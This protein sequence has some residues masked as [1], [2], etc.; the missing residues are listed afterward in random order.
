MSH[1]TTQAKRTSVRAISATVAALLLFCAINCWLTWLQPHIGNDSELPEHGWSYWS[2]KAIRNTDPK[3]VNVVVLG[4]SL[5]SAAITECDATLKKQQLDLCFY[6]GAS[7]LDEQMRSQFHQS[8]QTLNLAAPGQIPSDAYL[9]MKAALAN[10]ITPGVVIYGVA[11]RDFIDHTLEDPCD[12]E[13]FHYFY[14]TMDMT[15]C[16]GELLKNPLRKLDST[17]RQTVYLYSRAIPC[18]MTANTIG[19]GTLR[20]LLNICFGGSQDIMERPVKADIL[21]QFRPFDLEPGRIVATPL[22]GRGPFL[23]NIQ[24]YKDRYKQPS[25]DAYSTQ[26]RFLERLV[27]LCQNHDIEII[28]VNMPITRQ[29]LELLDNTWQRRYVDDLSRIASTHRID[30]LDQCEFDRYFHE[31]F[32]DSV[33]LNGVGGKKFI[34]R[35]VQCMANKSGAARAMLA[36]GCRK[37]RSMATSR[38]TDFAAGIQ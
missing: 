11:P 37:K 32:R 30:L 7:Y 29:N 16:P 18:S 15:D 33:H 8:Y 10:G 26:M 14:Q 23:D 38:A 6:R 36:A 25:L 13:A 9:T 27:A 35:L 5:V 22:S 21:R 4:S 19:S 20:L 1:H 31:D 28:L 17:L 3:K 2:V 34:N 24:D 12:T